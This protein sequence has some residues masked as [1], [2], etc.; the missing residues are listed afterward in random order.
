MVDENFHKFI[1]LASTDAD[2]YDTTKYL[3]KQGSTI[4]L[5]K[6]ENDDGS[7]FPT[8]RYVGVFVTY[9]W[10]CM[11]SRCGRLYKAAVG[12][13]KVQEYVKVVP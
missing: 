1:L 2:F 9:N 6:N 4:F 5:A 11:T 10:R 7:I 8:P 12:T 3:A 13:W